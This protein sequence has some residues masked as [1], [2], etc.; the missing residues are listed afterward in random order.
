M[1]ITR[2]R[3][4]LPILG[5]FFGV[6]VVELFVVHLLASLWS[7]KLAWFLTAAT[8]LALVQIAS[9]IHGLVKWPTVLD[10][11]RVTVRHGRSGRIVV[12][13]HNIISTEDVAFSPEERGPHV[14]RTSILAHPNVVLRL[15]DP[16]RKGRRW[17]KVIAMRL[18]DPVA[19]HVALR[20]RL[21]ELKG[22]A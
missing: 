3:Y 18:D 1:N 13:L 16:V 9:L 2:H 4:E 5:A 10:E 14:F 19:F 15:R 21:E 17:V 7:A 11:K 8:L 6:A 12:P 20:A 22:A